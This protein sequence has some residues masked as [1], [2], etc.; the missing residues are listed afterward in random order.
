MEAL[1]SPDLLR[2]LLV[3]IS[4]DGSKQYEKD[5][6]G[7]IPAV[8]LCKNKVK[9]IKYI[10]N[11]LC[12]RGIAMNFRQN[13]KKRK[14]Y[15]ILIGMSF[16]F[17]LMSLI[18]SV[19]YFQKMNRDN[20]QNTL[21]Y[22]ESIAR[23]VQNRIDS[24]L[25]LV[26]QIDYYIE[27][28]DLIQQALKGDE[29]NM[30]NKMDLMIVLSNLRKN[31]TN[32][33]DLC[34][35][36]E[37]EDT[38]IS[39]RNVVSPETYFENQC[40]M[41]DYNYDSWKNEYL[42]R[43]KDREF[44][45]VQKVRVS[46]T[47]DKN[48]IIYK[49]TIISV[50]DS[51]TRV[52]IIMMINADAI[53]KTIANANIA[54]GGNVLITDKSGNII[55]KNGDG[56][57]KYVQK[58][59]I[60]EKERFEE[61]KENYIIYKKSDILNLEY[62]VSLS[63]NE[64][65]YNVDSFM[66][67]GI[68][69]L[70][71][72][73]I[74]GIGYLYLSVKLSYKPIRMIMNKI[75]TGNIYIAEHENYSELDYINSKIDEFLKKE[76][77]Y[78]DQMLRLAKYNRVTRL[79]ELLRGTEQN[80]HAEQINW[81]Y[82]AFMTAI[83]RIAVMDDTTDSVAIQSLRYNVL[84]MLKEFTDVLKLCEFVEM[85]ESDIVVILNVNE[86]QADILFENIQ[87]VSN[88]I[89][90]VLEEEFG[91][92]IITAV[93]T[94]HGGESSLSRCYQEAMTAI[95][96]RSVN[97]ENNL[98]VIYYDKIIDMEQAKDAWYYWPSD[99]SNTMSE[100]VDKGDYEKIEKT[101]DEIVQFSIK[102]PSDVVILGECLYYNIF[103]ILLNISAKYINTYSMIDISKYDKAIP[104]KEN[105]DML[106]DRFRDFCEIT[107]SKNEGEQRL[108]NRIE[109][110]V[111]K[112]FAENSLDLAKVADN[113]QISVGYLTTYF[114]KYKNTT[115]LKYITNKRIAYAKALLLNTN[116]TINTIA[117][118]VGYTDSCVFAKIFKK[119]EGVTPSQYRNDAYDELTRE[120]E[121][122][123]SENMGDI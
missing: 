121:Q 7:R 5:T 21:G 95:D 61:Y 71:I 68:I 34:V 120:K 65:L 67:I 115:M 60:N 79:K 103:G 111:D 12:L 86:K 66:H 76:D 16:V 8:I 93:S 51:D 3:W 9:W 78:A 57:F 2:C 15:Y 24:D 63:R 59:F 114:K 105:M 89:S 30:Q 62:I 88:V 107:Q 110:Y 87:K 99:L 109:E 100:L 56:D 84:N 117:I 29:L 1:K 75:S 119:S 58:D 113:V 54:D 14:N 82:D 49:R 96:F 25:N 42:L 118:K 27:I 32:L 97:D 20:M 38:L 39:S 64:V 108:L 122:K 72:Y 55:L 92:T 17:I 11:M 48:I 4:R 6:A 80:R 104:F 13:L 46:K 18:I 102:K 47:I 123:E 70:L 81:A 90:N 50:L 98:N 10:R 40:Y 53:E 112:H 44:Y 74:V 43:P 33:D 73:L 36:L 19:F 52:H 45:P 106:K 28:N 83:I 69:L 22:N 77:I 91:A 35:Y 31:M 37:N 116:F 94:V 41:P 85:S 23:L 101:I 26:R